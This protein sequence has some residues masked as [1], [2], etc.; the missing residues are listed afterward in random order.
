MN[1]AR[2]EFLA[3]ATRLVDR[4]GKRLLVVLW[5]PAGSG[6]ESLLPL[7]RALSAADA[8]AALIL[9][10]PSATREDPA[11]FETESVMPVV[12]G[13]DPVW[14][15]DLPF[16]SVVAGAGDSAALSKIP[17]GIARVLVAPSAGT[18]A[19]WAVAEMGAG[20]VYD[21]YLAPEELDP[22]SLDAF[23]A[24]LQIF[25]APSL[26]EHDASVLT[27]LP[28]GAPVR[29]IEALAAGQGSFGTRLPLPQ[30][31][32]D[33]L[34]VDLAR[35]GL[36]CLKEGLF[37]PR[38]GRH[39]SQA[40]PESR[41]FR[42]LAAACF[43]GS[44]RHLSAPRAAP[45]R[46][47]AVRE[48]R[49]AAELPPD[50]RF[51]TESQAIVERWIE[52]RIPDLVTDIVIQRRGLRAGGDESLLRMLA[53]QPFHPQATRSMF[54]RSNAQASAGEIGRRAVANLEAEISSLRG[55]RL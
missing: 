54:H 20:S 23:R 14:L 36:T 3:L 18:P 49:A 9:A 1:S 13:G 24:A 41:F 2:E 29:T 27:V 26:R 45:S 51:G 42:Q 39:I 50:D 38:L 10:E 8:P 25:A 55:E 5:V 31:Q 30:D 22:P 32:P 46:L 35:A 19:L 4:S 28:P 7:S 15:A 43:A 6:L 47:E 37:A 48:I 16:R 33:P 11:P 12:R 40:Q 53:G 17:R 44:A 52:E 34:R 21:H